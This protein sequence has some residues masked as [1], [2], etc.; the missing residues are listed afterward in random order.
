MNIEGNMFE[1]LYLV[2]SDG[3]GIVQLTMGND[4]NPQWSPDG[5]TIAFNRLADCEGGG[6]DIYSIQ[7]DGSGLANLTASEASEASAFTW[8]P[9]GR[10]IAYFST[11]VGNET[12]GRTALK[13]MDADGSNQVNLLDL[14][15]GKIYSGSLAWSPDGMRLAFITPHQ[16]NDAHIYVIDR[17]GSNQ[18]QLSVKADHY[19]DLNWSPDGNWLAFAAGLDEPAIYALNVGS[20]NQP[21][22]EKTWVRITPPGGQYTYPRWQ[23]VVS[24]PISHANQLETLVEA[25]LN[26]DGTL[27]RIL[28]EPGNES[29]YFNNNPTYVRVLME[30]VSGQSIRSVWE[31]SAQDASVAY[32]TP[33]IIQVEGCQQFLAVLGDEGTGSGLRVFQW[34]GEG[35]KELLRVPG[36]YLFAE[37]EIIEGMGITAP[38]GSLSIMDLVHSDAKNLWVVRVFQWDGGEFRQIIQK[39][40]S[41]P[42]GG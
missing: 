32:L 41:Y 27:E 5:K 36:R 7:S 8:S 26:C 33:K 18:K 21:L 12:E 10:Q 22:D 39:E 25:D 31:F 37:P 23:P 24:G 17:D 40:V 29:H 14:G 11:S 19:F 15:S 9:D 42:G 30:T 34:D 20:T 4:I 3:S 38:P 16:S 28:V 6:H 13:L 2:H 1:P 35:M